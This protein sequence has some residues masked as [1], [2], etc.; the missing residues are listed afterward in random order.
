[1]EM[2]MW[3]SVQMKKYELSVN[4]PSL[5]DNIMMSASNTYSHWQNFQYLLPRISSSALPKCNARQ[6]YSMLPTRPMPRLA[7][8]ATSSNTTSSENRTQNIHHCLHAVVIAIY[9][10]CG[11]STVVFG[12][13]N[14]RCFRQFT[15]LN[16]DGIAM[17]EIKE[18]KALNQ[19]IHICWS[20]SRACM[21]NWDW[22]DCPL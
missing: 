14:A 16:N 15:L 17:I 18:T 2:T 8:D 3:S 12:N 21:G 13:I 22:S 7:F 10:L 6:K 19:Q 5:L 9:Y 1:M 20:V 11:S 4:I